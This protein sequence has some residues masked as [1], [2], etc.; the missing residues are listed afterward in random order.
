MLRVVA[1]ALD[2]PVEVFFDDKLTKS[3]IRKLKRSVERSA[4]LARRKEA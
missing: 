2:T 1:A 3:V 4:G